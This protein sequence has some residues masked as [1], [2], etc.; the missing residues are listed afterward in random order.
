MWQCRQCCQKRNGHHQDGLQQSLK[1]TTSRMDSKL[2]IL[3]GTV[4]LFKNSRARFALHFMRKYY[5]TQIL[6]TL[7]QSA[8]KN[9]WAINTPFSGNG[10]SKCCIIQAHLK[11]KVPVCTMSSS[12]NPEKWGWTWGYPI[13]KSP[14]VARQMPHISLL[15][16]LGQ[17]SEFMRINHEFILINPTLF[18]H[19]FSTSR[20]CSL[21]L[22]LS[23]L[24]KKTQHPSNPSWVTLHLLMHMPT[25]GE[26]NGRSQSH[27]DRQS[28]SI[29]GLART[30]QLNAPCFC[31]ANIHPKRLMFEYDK[32]I[33]ELNYSYSLQ[34]LL[35]LHFF[36]V[37]RFIPVGSYKYPVRFTLANLTKI[38]PWSQ[39]GAVTWHVITWPNRNVEVPKKNKKN[40]CTFPL[41][42][43]IMSI[44][45]IFRMISV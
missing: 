35:L 19:N 27:V 9:H 21:N 8:W 28:M 30:N 1:K 44:F 2:E 17:M 24:K 5:P 45:T 20:F 29:L 14:E 12:N 10:T 33:M 41:Y 23:S 13:R 6:V 3:S 42:L 38:D 4:V 11:T 34:F 16:F 7:L 26:C 43:R 31:W 39:C 32:T 25:K 37:G 36:N 15:S 22:N 40:T 18:C